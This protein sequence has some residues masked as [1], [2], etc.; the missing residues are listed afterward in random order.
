MQRQLF[1]L[2]ALTLLLAISAAPVSAAT[3]TLLDLDL[4][5]SDD[6]AEVGRLL[7]P[8]GN[9]ALLEVFQSNLGR[10]VF[11]S[12]GTSLGT[13]LLKLPLPSNF[14]I[15]I[16]Q[17]V[18]LF[19]SESSGEIWRTDGT[20]QGTYPLNGPDG[21][22]STCS[23]EAPAAMGAQVFF[24]GRNEARDCE[25]WTSDGTSAGTRLVKDL[26]P[27]SGWGSPFRLMTANRKVFFLSQAS[28]GRSLWISDGTPDGTRQVRD[29][30]EGD[31]RLLATLGSRLLFTA[32]RE[33]ELWV[34]D[35]TSE[36]TRQI[37]DF[38]APE[39]FRVT[40]D[41]EVFDGV[42]YFLVDDVTGGTDLWRSDGTE[43]GTYR[44]TAFGYATPFQSL[45]MA[46]AGNRLVFVADDGLTG[47]RFWTSLGTP[48]T[49]APLTGCD[50]ECPMPSSFFQ[51]IPMK[52]LAGRVL[53]AARDSA[54]GIE[55]WS[56][57]GT[58]P[59]TRLVRDL[60][61]GNC[62]SEPRRFS[63]LDGK[64]LFATG[65]FFASGFWLTDG[66]ASGTMRL[67]PADQ[68]LELS[69]E[70]GIAKAGNDFLFVGNGAGRS[71]QLW[72][73]N[74]SAAG[75]HL[76][77]LFGGG[78]GSEPSHF[79]ALGQQMLFTTCFDFF[80]R[81]VWRSDGTLEGTS[82]IAQLSNYCSS[83]GKLVKSGGLL[84]FVDD[85]DLWR[86]DGT[87]AGSFL[88]KTATF[89]EDIVDIALFGQNLIFLVHSYD[90]GSSLWTTN[91]FTAG[92]SK[93][94]DLPDDGFPSLLSAAGSRLYF[95]I[96]GRLW[97]SDGSAAGT[98]PL[99]PEDPD[100]PRVSLDIP[101]VSI[102][103][104]LFFTAHFGFELWV[105]DGTPAG[106]RPIHSSQ[107]NAGR[108]P[109]N[110]SEF[111]G[112]LYYMAGTSNGANG[113]WRTNGTAAGTV[114]LREL[115]FSGGDA[116]FTQVGNLLFFIA[117]D[118]EHGTELW[119]TDGTVEG[120]V[121]LRD[122]ANGT[123][124]SEP[125]LLTAANGVLFFTA[126][127]GEHGRELWRSDGS[128][129]GTILVRDIK[130]GVDSSNP[131]SLLA[132]GGRLFFAAGDGEHG[133]ELWESDGTAG[134]T[135]MVQDLAPGVPSSAPKEL[136][137]MNDFLFFSADD[138]FSGR[139]PWS[140][141]LSG[142][143]ACVPSDEVLCLGGGRFK[144]VA[145]W[146]DF[147]GRTGRGHGVS[148]TSD[149]GYFWFFSPANVEAVI[150]VLD[151]R[152]ING[153][154]WAFYG[155]LSN[156]EYILTV[157]DTET[158]ATRRYVNPPGLLASVGDVQAFGP[159][160]ATGS[161]LTLGPQ[162]IAAEPLIAEGFAGKAGACAPS[163]TRLCLNGGR[164]AVEVRWQSFD[165]ATGTG[166]AVPLSGGDTGYFWFFAQENVEVVLKVLDGRAV[167]GKFW[168]FYGALSSVEYTL[169][170]TDTET[171]R[172]K[173][174]RN[175]SGRLASGADIDAF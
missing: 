148:L 89:D 64:L 147:E 142:P 91:G 166:K 161:A 173:T 168:V 12:D 158:G 163:S 41:V 132:A 24:A 29:F 22:V 123:N 45:A 151:G 65:S 5:P 73:S 78:Q 129:D 76:V 10:G 31:I 125:S 86:T 37:T 59:G 61:P 56:T 102:G 122:I 99:T 165:G 107:D 141:P 152:G 174:Y 175:P 111:R 130:D 95:A 17:R 15:T 109:R 48:A 60:C 96:D 164:F 88:L 144:V 139:E 28:G 18:A 38:A 46:K 21:R 30:A 119:R 35:G 115:S 25:L 156:V 135:R 172:V 32:L 16:Q 124:S 63:E 110:L 13:Q 39:P 150:K 94:F 105:T 14:L 118:S 62:D 68:D 159:L 66:T 81:Q 34:S 71:K 19:A 143:S 112:D 127:D 9:S 7:G 55:L 160:G 53:F 58:G 162:G 121:L 77:T 26:V 82:R 103:N 69:E 153:H 120:T 134:G 155:A 4:R 79:V 137:V 138:G 57:D 83:Q 43:A 80:T 170:V 93:L 146:R 36:G 67:T 140:Y 100:G 42:A 98:R 75:E 90:S 116:S 74:G 3:A 1:A 131:S 145:T 133:T 113:L 104:L 117:Y 70:A 49:V 33:E 50:G 23:S 114:L 51:D 128:A 44:A 167:N 106:T 47:K 85:E 54:H 20:R 169:T 40:Q 136:T 84:F 52:S 157:T 2:F 92:T 108:F 8:L 126:R 6:S 72:A 87:V 149:T 154:H 171:G 101:P 97:V 11:I 27:G